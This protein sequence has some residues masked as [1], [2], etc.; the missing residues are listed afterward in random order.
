MTTY[1]AALPGSQWVLCDSRA[2]LQ[3]DSGVLSLCLDPSLLAEGVATT[4]RGSVWYI[5][6]QSSQRTLLLAGPTE[7]VTVLAAVPPCAGEPPAAAAPTTWSLSQRGTVSL[8]QLAAAGARTS[9]SSS[10]SSSSSM[11][12]PVAEWHSPDARPTVVAALPERPTCTPQ[13]VLGFEDGR[14]ALLELPRDGGAGVLRWCV[15]RHSSAVISLAPHPGSAL[16]LATS[17]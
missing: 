12:V 2:P 16:L 5:D 7:R 14:L 10:S 1:T 3:L 9:S 6:L 17:R 11:H 8:W 4:R 13:C 15:G